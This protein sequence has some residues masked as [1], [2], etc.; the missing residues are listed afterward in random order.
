MTDE[1]AQGN[2]DILGTRLTPSAPPAFEYPRPRRNHWPIGAILAFGI[3]LGVLIVTAYGISTDE[4]IE[5]DLGADALRAYS[6][7]QEYF[8]DISLENHGP[9]YFM[10][11]S[12]GSE[13]FIRVFPRWTLPDGRHFTNY[14]T[15]LAGVFCFYL[16]SLRLVRQ[17]SALMGTILF[18]S[19]PLLFG[20]AFINQKDIPFMTFFLAVMALGLAAGGDRQ[21]VDG[22]D[23]AHPP[24]SFVDAI[25]EYRNR[26]RTGWQA[27]EEP[28]R[29][30]LGACLLLGLLLMA[31]LF[32]VGVIHRLGESI[33]VAAYDGHAPWPIQSLYA[34]IATDAYKTPLPLY[35]D[36]YHSFFASVRFA[37][38]GLFILAGV[39]AYRLVFGSHDNISAGRWFKDRYPALVGGAVLLG[40][41]ICVR[42]I[43][44]FAG[45]LVSLYLF[46]QRGRKALLPLLLYWAVAASV[47]YATWPYLW[48][49]PIR[50]MTNS[51]FAIQDVGHHDVLFQGQRLDSFIL[52]PSYLPTLLVLELTEPALV[53]A[54]LGLG[55][56]LWRSLM[57]R[58]R[59][60]VTGLVALWAGVPISWQIIGRVPVFNNIRLFL[61]II[62]PLLLV[63]CVGLDAL[64]NHARRPWMRGLLLVLAIAPGVWGIIRL[65]PYEYTYFNSLAGGVSGAYGYYNLDYWCTSLKEATEIVNQIS[66]EGGTVQVF[67][68]LQNAAPYARADLKLVDRFALSAEANT[69]ALCMHRSDRWRDT[70][71]FRLVYQVR[72]GNAVFAEVWQRE[73]ALPS[74]T[75]GP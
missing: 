75:S 29:R 20:S 21:P 3:V 56:I 44:L 67:G 46:Y 48:S 36:R 11:S 38:A 43:G 31:D 27:L 34:R 51:L 15:F 16:I 32:F 65:Y 41:A 45:V 9:V 49:D 57:R 19:Q 14:L 2:S 50:G 28:K 73:A 69:V 40:L 58:T 62:P 12:A 74:S 53:L 23:S 7:S 10:L 66:A 25:G 70:S 33:V 8:R 5:A 22:H 37:L 55:A 24:E 68:S 59:G 6:G 63:A 60:I 71:G 4:Y 42:Q 17:A 72:R 64:L 52:P 47:T 61:F 13:A 26:L 54:C 18:A 35:L 39:V 1:S 30:M